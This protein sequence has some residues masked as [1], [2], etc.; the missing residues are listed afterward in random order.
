M[1][2]TPE[3]GIELVP[4]VVHLDMA[5]LE[6]EEEEEEGVT[7]MNLVSW[8]LASVLAR[9]APLLLITSACVTA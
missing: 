6:T 5:T 3:L 1:Y 7:R 9:F 2:M 4:G 8:G